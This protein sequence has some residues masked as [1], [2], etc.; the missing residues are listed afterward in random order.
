MS[1]SLKDL[2]QFPIALGFFKKCC[3]FN[4]EE[5]FKVQTEKTE[6]FCFLCPYPLHWSF[7]R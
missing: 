6:L 4:L 5:A 3:V 7:L 1:V 2:G